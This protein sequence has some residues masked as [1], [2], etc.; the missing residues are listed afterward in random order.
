MIC[1]ENATRRHF[2]IDF[3]VLRQDRNE[4][5]LSAKDWFFLI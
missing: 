2:Y 1:K 5:E 3:E 4:L